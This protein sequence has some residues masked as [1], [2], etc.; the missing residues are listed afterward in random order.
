[1]KERFPSANPTNNEK[2]IHLPTRPESLSDSSSE[3][4]QET[5]TKIQRLIQEGLQLC[6]APADPYPPIEKVENP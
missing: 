6:D 2:I 1:M 3:R 4:I 5:L